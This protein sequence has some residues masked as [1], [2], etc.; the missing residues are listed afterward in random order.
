MYLFHH[1]YT[2]LLLTGSWLCKQHRIGSLVL[3][4]H[5]VGDIFLP[6]GK[7]YSYAEDHIRATCSRAA[8]EVHKAVGTF[9]FVLFIVFFAIP[10]LVVFGGLIVSGMKQHHWFTCCG[11][12][13]DPCPIGPLWG[14]TLTAILGLL[15]RELFACFLPQRACP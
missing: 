6:I 1:L 13:C 9:F 2:V 12:L 10:R 7:C 11:P 8:V 14:T 4:L 15:Y 5:D 3:I